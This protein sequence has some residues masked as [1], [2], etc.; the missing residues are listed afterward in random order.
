MSRQLLDSLRTGRPFGWKII[1]RDLDRGQRNAR[2]LCDLDHGNA[3]QHV[4]AV[5]ALVA[6]VAPAMDQSLGFIE[7]DG[8]NADPAATRDFAHGK[9]NADIDLHGRGSLTSSIHE[10]L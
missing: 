5:A 9:R 2:P 4:A 1:Q 6:V 7:V 10:V 8:G 3:P